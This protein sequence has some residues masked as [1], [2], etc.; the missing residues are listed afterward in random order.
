[1]MVR[2]NDDL[3]DLIQY[4]L[5][6]LVLGFK[7]A[8]GKEDFEVCASIKAEMDRRK[9]TSGINKGILQKILLLPEEFPGNNDTP[10]NNMNF[11]AMFK[12]Y[13]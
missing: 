13:L 2:K 10:E 12:N 3:T 11:Q 9:E 1:M 5:I 4:P 8:L 6:R 7:E